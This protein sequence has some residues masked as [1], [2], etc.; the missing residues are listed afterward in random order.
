MLTND[1]VRNIIKG[2]LENR[3]NLMKGTTE[4][5]MNQ[6]GGFLGPLMRDDLP[7]IKNLLLPL[8]KSALIALGSTLVVS[9]IDTAVQ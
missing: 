2:I 8:A 1:E 3:A 7:F 6:K 5:I 9:P 4:K